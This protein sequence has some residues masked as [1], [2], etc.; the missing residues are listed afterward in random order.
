MNDFK[1]IAAEHI[2]AHA[3]NA[4]MLDRVLQNSQGHPEMSDKDVK[5]AI[6]TL[7]RIAEIHGEQLQDMLAL[8]AEEPKKKFWKFWK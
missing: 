2:H 6:L 1:L 4:E 5:M 3:F 7:H 8:L